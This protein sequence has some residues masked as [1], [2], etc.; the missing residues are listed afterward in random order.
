MSI[1]L[2]LTTGAASFLTHLPC[3]SSQV[4]GWEGRL[5]ILREGR[6]MIAARC[7]FTGCLLC[8][9]GEEI[10]KTFLNIHDY[11]QGVVNKG[12]WKSLGKFYHK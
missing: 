3:L 5:K 1:S 11:S 8:S 10:L 4:I 12:N 9:S 6:G 2:I 7:I